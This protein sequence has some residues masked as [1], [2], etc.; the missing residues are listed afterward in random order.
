M[1]AKD[2]YGEYALIGTNP[3]GNKTLRVKDYSS[4]WKIRFHE[5]SE[6]IA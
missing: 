3:E 1:L 5:H 2:N 6:F 4:R